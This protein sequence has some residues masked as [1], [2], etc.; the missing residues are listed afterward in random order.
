M[1]HSKEKPAWTR[2]PEK[3]ATCCLCSQPIYIDEEY[4]VVR[5]KGP[6]PT[7]YFH[8]ECFK[9]ERSH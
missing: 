7:T 2:L 3:G 4:E 8:T 9:K 6:R 5:H 1:T